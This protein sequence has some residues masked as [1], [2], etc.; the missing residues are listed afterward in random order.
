MSGFWNGYVA[1]NDD[2]RITYEQVF[3][4]QQLTN[5][6]GPMQA[7]PGNFWN[8]TGPSTTTD[9]APSI[10]A[11]DI[12]PADAVEIVPD[13]SN[14]YANTFPAGAIEAPTIDA[15]PVQAPDIEAPAIEAP[16]IEPPTPPAP[17]GPDMTPG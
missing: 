1:L 2:I 11:P 7:D 6:Y 9:G 17:A 4:G 10:E 3:Y 8:G 15:T 12:S 16:P 14:V 13:V 5:S